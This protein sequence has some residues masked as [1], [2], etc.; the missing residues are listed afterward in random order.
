MRT[1]I[2]FKA[3]ALVS[4]VALGSACAGV[5][6]TTTDLNPSINRPAT[7]SAAIAVTLS[8]R[9]YNRVGV[10]P[11]IMVGGVCL[12]ISSWQL[13]QL[14]P[15]TDGWTLLPWIAI[16]GAAVSAMRLVTQR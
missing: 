14:T 4:A 9:L 3:I 8:G 12:V 16:R 2:T 13:S 15:L 6:K 10:R 11:L 7:C 1:H 5:R